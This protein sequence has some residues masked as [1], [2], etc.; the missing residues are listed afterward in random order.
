MGNRIAISLVLLAAIIGGY[1]VYRHRQ[2]EKMDAGGEVT[3]QGCM[4]PD[5]K[6]RFDKGDPGDTADGQSER[7]ARAARAEDAA[8]LPNA[9]VD[10]TAP[11]AASAAGASAAAATPATTPVSAPGPGTQSTATNVPAPGGNAGGSAS[12]PVADTLSPN[13]PNG[14]AFGGKGTYQWYRQGNLTWRLDTVSGRSCIVYAT[15]EEWR[16]QVVMSHGC[17]REA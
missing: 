11:A 2:E 5:E 15:M 17:G 10:A 14:M 9:K 3:C 8:G 12:M 7:K 13:A 1:F 16:K 6:A 4:T